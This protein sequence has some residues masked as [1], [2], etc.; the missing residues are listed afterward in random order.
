MTNVLAAL[1][2]VMGVGQTPPAAPP[3]DPATQAVSAAISGLISEQ[4]SGRPMPG[5]LVTLW[6]AGSSERSREVVA[7]AQGRY[8][9]FPA[10]S[11]EREFEIL[12]YGFMDDHVHLLIRGTSVDSDFRSTMTLLRAANRARI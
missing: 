7:D 4:G 10:S 3:R 9:I 11:R 6:T 1:L 2:L 8:E 12:A 5:A